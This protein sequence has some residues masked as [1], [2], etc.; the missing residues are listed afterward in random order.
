MQRNCKPIA[1]AVPIRG[2]G[3][4]PRGAARP[5]YARTLTLSINRG[6]RESR[7]P[8]APMGPVQKKHGGRT[9]GSTG[10]TPAFPAQWFSAYFAL[11][12]VT[13][14]SCHRRSRKSPC[15]N[16]TPASGRQDHTTSPSAGAA[17]V[18][19]STPVHRIPPQR[20][21]DRDPPLIRRETPGFKPVICPTAKAE[22]FCARGWTHAPPGARLICPS[23]YLPDFPSLHFHRHCEPSE[24][25][26]SHSGAMQSIE[27][28]CAIA[29]RRISRF[30]VRC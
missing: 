23:G 1:T 27:L 21:D 3:L 29:H 12:P 5:G 22:Y 10:I 6:R 7:V 15:E 26:S 16:L 4:H 9:T 8:I 2:I 20:C 13:G 25:G 14:L 11:S 19:R 28:R 24:A 30:R 18:A 17:L